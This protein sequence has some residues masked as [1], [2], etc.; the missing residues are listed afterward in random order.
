ME[1]LFAAQRVAPIFVCIVTSLVA[2][3]SANG[4]LIRTGAGIILEEVKSPDG[5]SEFNFLVLGAGPWYQSKIYNALGEDTS[6]FY[7]EKVFTDWQSVAS[8]LFGTWRMV[9]NYQSR[10]EEHS[11]T[12]SPLA[13]ED[14]T[15]PFPIISPSH[16][17]T[18]SSP[19][20]VTVEG[21]EVNGGLSGHGVADLTHK[22]LGSAGWRVDFGAVSPDASIQLRSRMPSQYYSQYVSAVTSPLDARFSVVAHF[23]IRRGTTVTLNPVII[24]EPSGLALLATGTALLSRCFRPARRQR[25]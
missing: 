2:S 7:Y 6:G 10:E 9:I 13:Y 21:G 24:P 5:A 16:G 18:V 23:S 17:S 3:Y 15:V 12:V 22:Y 11:F 25:V 14:I 1:K 8:R 19:F 4:D 20:Y